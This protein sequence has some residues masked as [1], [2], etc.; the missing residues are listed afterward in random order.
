MRRFAILVAAVLV[1]LAPVSAQHPGFTAEDMLKVATLS[2]ADFSDDG[3]RV[4]VTVRRAYDNAEVDNYR[5]GDPT[6]TAPS[7]ARLL[8]IDAPTGTTQT[9]FAD[10]VSFSRAA[11]SHDGTRLAIL[12]SQPIGPGLTPRRRSGSL[13]VVEGSERS[14]S[15]GE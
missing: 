14:E 12:L 2:I 5:Y 7:L 11:W 8:V 13:S 15:K 9:P 4:A 10:L 3:A 1:L 6:Y